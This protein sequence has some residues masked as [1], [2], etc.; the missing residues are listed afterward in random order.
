M[1]DY[2]LRKRVLRRSGSIVS[3]V[4]LERIIGWIDLM[5]ALLILS[6][7]ALFA[8]YI[9]PLLTPHGILLAIYLLAWW[10]VGRALC[11]L[12]TPRALCKIISPWLWLSAVPLHSAAFIYLKPQSTETIIWH[13]MHLAVCA[14][15]WSRRWHSRPFF[16]A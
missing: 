11:L 2:S 10:R 8:E 6:Q 7:P 16:R 9:Y 1:S 15:L 4:K 13:L 14:V 12:S 5:I 3:S